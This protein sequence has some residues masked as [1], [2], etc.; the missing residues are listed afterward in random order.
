MSVVYAY[1]AQRPP[2]EL[3]C[4]QWTVGET[5]TGDLGFLNDGQ[6]KAVVRA[7][8]DLWGSAEQV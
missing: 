4:A 2:I 5:E 8:G 3:C 7:D 1:C 6:L